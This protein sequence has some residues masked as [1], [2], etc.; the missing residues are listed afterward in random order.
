M[1]LFFF[2]FKTSKTST[3]EQFREG[4]NMGVCPKAIC[5]STGSQRRGVTQIHKGNQS[6]ICVFTFCPHPGRATLP[7]EHEPRGPSGLHSPPSLS[8]NT[9]KID[10]HWYLRTWTALISSYKSLPSAR[11]PLP[12]PSFPFRGL[13]K[14]FRWIPQKNKQKNAPL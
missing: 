3:S 2:F 11:S 10:L 5:S 14:G 9:L 4:I 12:F 8:H 13:Q 7:W 6:L 1:T